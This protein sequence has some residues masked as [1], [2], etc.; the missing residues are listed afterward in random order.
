MET[1]QAGLSAIPFFLAY[2]TSATPPKTDFSEQI[3]G[4]L[5]NWK[6]NI[7]LVKPKWAP[8]WNPWGCQSGGI[9]GVLP[10]FLDQ[11]FC[12]GKVKADIVKEEETDDPSL[13]PCPALLSI[14]ETGGCACDRISCW[15]PICSDTR[16]SSHASKEL[17]SCGSLWETG[18][19]VHD[20]HLGHISSIYNGKFRTRYLHSHWTLH[21]KVSLCARK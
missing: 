3:I 14:K 12:R 10:S 8:H 6:A 1:P 21:S 2:S 13:L 16:V 19:L 9:H 18:N 11:S 15:A 17:P 4:V 5:I 20:C 7:I